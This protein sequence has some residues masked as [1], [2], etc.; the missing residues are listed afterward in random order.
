MLSLSLSVLLCALDRQISMLT[1]ASRVLSAELIIL[2]AAAGVRGPMAGRMDGAGAASERSPHSATARGSAT[3]RDPVA[4]AFAGGCYDGWKAAGG[5]AAATQQ[6]LQQQQRQQQ[7]VSSPALAAAL[8]LDSGAQ[9]AGSPSLASSRSPSPS[10]QQ[11]TPSS[12]LLPAHCHL[13]S[14][15]VPLEDVCLQA[16]HS[17]KFP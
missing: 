7:M 3:S 2:A 16:C 8:Q 17:R 6:Q 13:N 11:V 5:A 1:M 15:W 10:A 4:T 12:S 9:L 14:L